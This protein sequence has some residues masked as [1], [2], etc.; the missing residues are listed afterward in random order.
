M[1]CENSKKKNTTGCFSYKS[2]YNNGLLMNASVELI[3][4]L[5]R[6][7]ISLNKYVMDYKG[8]VCVVSVHAGGYN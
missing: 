5:Q 2:D 7:D 8:A 1:P 6:Q 3:C 4:S